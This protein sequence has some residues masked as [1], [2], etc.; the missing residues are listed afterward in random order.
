MQTRSGRTTSTTSNSDTNSNFKECNSDYSFNATF[1]DEK[2]CINDTYDKYNDNIKKTKCC[3]YFSTI[4]K[5]TLI[6]CF[7]SILHWTLVTLYISWCYKPG[8]FGAITNIFTVGSPIC[9]ALNRIQSL[10]SDH[11][12]AL[13]IS[14]VV[15]FNTAIQT[16]FHF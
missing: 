9:I 11:F 10:I 15:G 2:N 4:L 1:P 8:I 6:V 16:L 3:N 12:I 7:L 13:F 14:S 5:F